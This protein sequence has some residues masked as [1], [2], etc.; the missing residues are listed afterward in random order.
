MTVPN[1]QGERGKTDRSRKGLANPVPKS[2]RSDSPLHDPAAA[3][4]G[5]RRVRV[6]GGRGPTCAASPTL[7]P[8]LQLLLPPVCSQSL[9]TA[10][11]RS[12]ASQRL[13]AMPSGDSEILQLVSTSNFLNSILDS[14]SSL[15][16]GSRPSQP[17][18]SS[19]LGKQMGLRHRRGR[20]LSSGAGVRAHL[21]RKQ[22]VKGSPLFLCAPGHQER[23]C[24]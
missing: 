10:R 1:R 4:A 11:L 7:S 9:L 15:T 19:P 3:A 20:G 8:V 14:L 22:R 24:R 23:W 2:E 12:L 6:E 21:R 5:T 18:G 16:C 17:K 13:V